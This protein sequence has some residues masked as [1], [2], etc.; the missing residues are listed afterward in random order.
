MTFSLRYGDKYFTRPAV[1]V[2]CKRFARDRE[3]VVDEVV[4]TTNAMIA[5][6]DSLCRP[7]VV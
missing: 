6:V 3:S 4:S 1:H 5:A 2:W 7:T